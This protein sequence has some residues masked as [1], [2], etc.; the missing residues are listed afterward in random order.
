ML[1]L[2]DL[3]GTLLD[4]IQDLTAATNYALRS[5]FFPLRT[6]KECLQFVGNGVHKLLERALPLH[7]QTAA[8]VEKIYPAFLSYYNEHLFDFTK[9]YPGICAT[10]SGLQAKGIELAVASNK[11]QAAVEKIISHFFPTISFVAIFGQRTG[12]PT[13][14]NPTV[15]NEILAQTCTARKDCLY[16]GDSEV[17]MQTAR[18]AS[19]KSCAVTWGFRSRLSLE[20]YKPDYLIDQPDQLLQIID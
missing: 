13:K 19:V 16:V 11:Y 3:D 20:K 12:I 14:P 4:T 5:G 18:N 8:Q 6:E 7:V 2:F 17:D 15:V 10:L 1:V 9:P